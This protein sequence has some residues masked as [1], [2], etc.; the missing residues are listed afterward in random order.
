[1]AE[2]NSNVDDEFGRSESENSLI[3]DASHDLVPFIHFYCCFRLQ[4][5]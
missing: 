4:V 3:Y 1:M 2:A 5:Y